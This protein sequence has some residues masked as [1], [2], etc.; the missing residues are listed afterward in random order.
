MIHI[1]SLQ[2]YTWWISGSAAPCTIPTFGGPPVLRGQRLGR[3]PQ[4]EDVGERTICSSMVTHA[5]EHDQDVSPLSACDIWQVLASQPSITTLASILRCCGTS[6]ALLDGMLVHEHIQR[7]GLLHNIFLSNCLVLMYAQCESMENAQQVFNR[8][9]RPNSYSWSILIKGYA[10]NGKLDEARHV[11]A[12]IPNPDAVA[13]NTMIAAYAQKQQG[14]KALDLFWKMQANGMEPDT[15]TLTSTLEACSSFAGLGE[16]Q[17]LL[18]YI[19]SS[20][21]AEDNSVKTSLITLLGK[22]GRLDD[23]WEVFSNL[24]NRDVVS[25]NAMMAAYAQNGHIWQL[26]KQ[27]LSFMLQ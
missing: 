25:W 24:L 17:E 19:S 26:W 10:L 12:Q 1:Q 20:K 3:C 21:F 13:Y 11:L 23:A 16:A 15:V 22:F 8:I 2:V 14:R 7:Q 27:G 9:P 6:K 18:A 4:R 5:Y